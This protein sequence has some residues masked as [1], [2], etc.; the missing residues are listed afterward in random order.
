MIPI[1]MDIAFNAPSM[2]TPMRPG[3][4]TIQGSDAYASEEARSPGE[5]AV[6]WTSRTALRPPVSGFSSRHSSYPC[7]SSDIQQ[8]LSLGVH[9]S[10]PSMFMLG[11][12]R[13]VGQEI[14]KSLG[15]SSPPE[16]ASAAIRKQISAGYPLRARYAA[17]RRFRASGGRV[18]EQPSGSRES[19]LPGAGLFVLGPL[20]RGLGGQT[21]VHP[22]TLELGLECRGGQ[23][24]A[25]VGL[26]GEDFGEA[27]VALQTGFGQAVEDAFDRV[28]VVA[29]AAESC[30][31]LG[32]GP[33]AVR[34]EPER[35]GACL[36]RALG[37]WKL[38]R[39]GTRLPG[40]L[41]LPGAASLPVAWFGGGPAATR[42]DPRTSA[43]HGAFPSRRRAE[44]HWQSALVLGGASPVN[45]FGT[46]PS[47]SR[48]RFSMS[49]ATS[50]FS[51]RNWRA[52]S[53][54]C[55]I[56]VPS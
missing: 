12:G 11:L 16:T 19:K 34:E 33:L 8:S 23:S 39:G 14:G 54:P 28:R 7:H 1:T 40:P 52:F 35:D 51:R 3:A 41:A 44:T 24:S 30:L 9:T 50:G 36:L 26:G 48:T 53:R 56:C 37:L 22:A 4:P 10:Q 6:V 18:S 43:R 15:G 29:F 17:I 2:S 27:L 47:A 49:I 46:R 42:P 55:P 45:S 20:G 13:K 38:G 5:G 32:P 31:E 21:L 25:S